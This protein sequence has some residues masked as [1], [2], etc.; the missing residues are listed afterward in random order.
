[1]SNFR[2][3]TSSSASSPRPSVV[4]LNPSICRTLAQPSRSV[5]SSS[6]IRRLREALTSAEMDNGSRAASPSAAA[7]ERPESPR[8]AA[9]D[10]IVKL[11]GER[12]GT[13]VMPTVAPIRQDLNTVI[14]LPNSRHCAAVEP[15]SSVRTTDRAPSQ[16]KNAAIKLQHSGLAT[17]VVCHIRHRV[18][19]H[20]DITKR[21]HLHPTF[22]AANPQRRSP[23]PYR[24][25]GLILL[26]RDLSRLQ[27]PGATSAHPRAGLRYLC[28]SVR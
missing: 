8:T 7:R 19:H 18:L 6:T 27:R 14:Q 26:N 15:G 13:P 2:R 21:V 4:T 20:I 11:L 1:M 28:A 9:E 25:V 22:R 5:R 17:V 16:R 12:G 23:E 24:S 10:D 3:R